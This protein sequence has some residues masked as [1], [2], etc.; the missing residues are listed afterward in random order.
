MDPEP[1][2]Y[3]LDNHF[4]YLESKYHALVIFGLFGELR[5]MI[6]QQQNVLNF[7][8]TFLTTFYEV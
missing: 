7:K 8:T 5:K 1:H 3:M 2:C 4:T 6:D